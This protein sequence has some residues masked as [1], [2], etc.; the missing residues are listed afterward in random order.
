MFELGVPFGAFVIYAVVWVIGYFV[1]A[2]RSGRRAEEA[3]GVHDRERRSERDE[4]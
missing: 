2:A 3:P 4:E 1:W